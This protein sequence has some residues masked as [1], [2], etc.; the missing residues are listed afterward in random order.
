[1][2]TPTPQPGFAPAPVGSDAY[3]QSVQ[4][5]I[6]AYARQQQ[7]NLVYRAQNPNDNSFLPEWL[8]KPIEYIGSKMYAVWRPVARVITTPLLAADFAKAEEG[9]GRGNQWGNLFDGNVWDRAYHDAKHVS[10][11]QAIYSLGANAFSTPEELN[12][13][14]TAGQPTGT[15]IWDNPN[16]VSKFFDHGSQKY[17]SGG[18]DAAVSWYADPF[19]LA[20]KA[21]GIASRAAYVRPVTQ[22]RQVTIA[23]KAL[24]RVT[25]ATTAKIHPALGFQAGKV[26]S[27]LDKILNSSAYTKFGDAIMKAHAANPDG[28]EKWVADQ[29]WARNSSDGM[30]LANAIGKAAR[31]GRAELDQV[32]KISMGEEGAYGAARSSLLANNPQLAAQLEGISD[33]QKNLPALMPANPSP[34]QLSLYSKVLD[35]HANQIKAINDNQRFLESAINAKGS[36]GALHFNPVLSPL[37]ASAGAGVRAADRA[38]MT[39]LEGMRKATFGASLVK[40][41]LYVRPIRLIGGIGSVLVQ[42]LRALSIA[43][44]KDAWN[45]I[46]PNGWVD[47][48]D[49]QAYRE[50]DAQ[51]A[52]AKVFSPTERANHVSDF[53]RT[54]N[55]STRGAVL[56]GLE[57]KAVERIA[58]KYGMDADSA[59]TVYAQLAGQKA[60][61]TSGRVYSTAKIQLADGSFAPID[62]LD[63]A[64]NLVAAHPILKTQLE[65]THVMMDFENFDKVLRVNAPAITRLVQ[66]GKNAGEAADL[67]KSGQA[68]VRATAAYKAMVGRDALSS[69]ADV[70][71]SLW[72]FNA[73]L[74]VGYGPRAISDD[75]LGQI[76]RFGA[77]TMF[78]ERAAKGGGRGIIRSLNNAF[79]DPTLYHARRTGMEGGIQ[80]ATERIADLTRKQG[81]IEKYLP[82]NVNAPVGRAA[83]RAHAK[84]V[85]DLAD[86]QREIERQ[87]GIISDTQ[88]ALANLDKWRAASGKGYVAL[89]DGTAIPAAFEGSQG[90]LFKDLNSGRR[91]VD[92]MMGGT[93]VDLLNYLRNGDWGVV[94]AARASRSEYLSAWLR[95]VQRQI[96]QDP[97]AREAVAGRDLEAWFKT[98]AGRAYRKGTPY[99]SLDPAI[100]ADRVQA[101]VDAYLPTVKKDGSFF[102][103][104]DALRRGVENGLDD[105]QIRKLM[106]QA[107]DGPAGKGAN[108]THLPDIQGEGLAYVLGTS[109]VAQ[110]SSD[111]INRFYHVMNQLPSEILSRNPLFKTLYRSHAQELQDLAKSQGLTH[112]NNRQIQELADQARKRALRD[113]K[114]F[115]FNMDHE[116]K[117]A[118]TMRF[119][120]PFFGPMQESFTRWG[121][122]MAEKPETAAHFVQA[123]TAPIRGGYTF[124]SNGNKIDSDGY[125]TDPK[126]GQ[127]KLVAKGDMHVRF[128]MPDYMAKAIGMD[129]GSQIDMPID[130]LNLVLQNDPWYNPGTGPWV[131]VP[132]NFW[133]N[134]VSPDSLL[135]GDNLQKL[136]ILPY[137]MDTSSYNI[138]QGSLAKSIGLIMDPNSDQA[139]NLTWQIMQAEDYKWKNHMRDTE[140]TWSEV[141]DKARKGIL[142]RAFLK[143]VLP[144]SASFNDPYQFFRDQY[145]SMQQADPINADEQFYDRY[146]DAATVFMESLSK[147]KGGLP[148]TAAAI[149][150]KHKWGDLISE[151]P[152]LAGLIA[153]P[154]ASG[155]YSQSAYR[156][157]QAMGDRVKITPEEALANAKADEGWGF[158]QRQMKGLKAQLLDR[159]L[160]SF[161]DAGAEDLKAMKKATVDTL[162]DP[163]MQDGVTPNQLYNPDWAKQYLTIDLSKDDRLASA[164]RN[165]AQTAELKDRPDIQGLQLY[166]DARDVIKGELAARKAAG[167]SDDINA[168][169]NQDLR[170]IFQD[171]INSLTEQSLAFQALH[172]RW[173]SR[174]M[175]DH[176]GG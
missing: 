163:T 84:R 26:T 103:E 159:G 45:A 76:A 10:P 13:K 150:A 143:N 31:S 176:Y 118:H 162:A 99:A 21:A 142:L 63:D 59:R 33:F 154:E 114:K 69:L 54:D 72:K 17:I 74:R 115:T 160:Q 148:A 40:N 102:K 121:R 134:H 128:Q 68:G 47:L 1:M 79:N 146:G 35:Y 135:G 80:T 86:L 104:G 161:D 24:E 39:K 152:E 168:Q 78:V 2:A 51:L 109:K 124:D 88:S 85:S 19:V 106:E 139:Q 145:R 116:T 46:R 144:V 18:L 52:S 111:M 140:P 11:G 120:A 38:V 67:I 158:F 153:G 105:G 113:V 141:K 83:R 23:G 172:D 62:S 170:Q 117:L 3:A 53:M 137:G 77:Y 50:V 25:G 119:I 48:H 73:L 92:T 133:A 110:M 108:V 89:D 65:N 9:A 171:N 165:I 131:Q 30:A 166:L 82:P 70:L 8:M 66:A 15:Y 173:L 14:L 32:L 28:I 60:A 129:G 130:T 91:T 147:N 122:I 81:Q 57:T 155:T 174:D 138:L 93:A 95:N 97:A 157:Q 136:G 27:N 127:R 125:V 41:S 5:S 56:V 100:H 20:G 75:F 175:F 94:E 61:I 4:Q 6:D 44:A 43:P 42:P 87:H 132:A 22:T 7:A 36:L 96:A 55:P 16:N 151:Y 164:M 58:A 107:Y 64:G 37:A 156:M 90:A 101:H 29:P 169:Q 12:R 167:G 149:A 126:T 123:H 112:M 34:A 49:T 71:G 98:E